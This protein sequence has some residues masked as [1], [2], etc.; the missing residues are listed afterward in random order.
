MR[1]TPTALPDSLRALDA[2]SLR[3]TRRVVSARRGARVE[4]DGRALVDF[5]SNDYLG[6]ASEPSLG[7]ALAE[8]ARTCGAGAAASHLVSGHQRAHAELE[9]ALAAYTRRER[10]LLFST[11]YMANLG[12]V[13][14][15]AGRGD[16]IVE[17]RLNHASLLDASRLAGARVR[18]FAHADAAACEAALDEGG[19]ASSPAA[20]RL[21][22]TDGVFSMDGDVAPV[23]PLAALATRRDAWLVVDDAH[24]LGVLGP[25]GGGVLEAAGLGAAAVPALVGTFGKAFGTFGAFVAGDAPLIEWLVQRARTYAYTT[26]LPAAIAV[27]TRTA[28]D[29]AARETWRRARVL[30]HV[31][32]FRAAAARS[33]VPLGAS[34]TPIQ[35][36]IVGGAE[37]AVA[38]SDALARRGHWVAAIRPPTV[39]RG[40]ARL[41]VSLS[42]AHEERD[43]D[44]LVAALA[45]V[46]EER[47][48][49]TARGAD[50]R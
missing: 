39:P 47:S 49:S 31:D 33:G 12:V 9:A 25:T 21:I 10:A 27:A 32:R 30:A 2:G 44:A 13:T 17:D 18:R 11:G 1:R 23:V 36:V 45:E 48:R 22:A 4:V 3:R 6:L 34:T 40:T 14:A 8:G 38:V 35:P 16:L 5:C 19:A 43:V 29:L 41:R 42:A 26:A 46:L 50:A 28:L 20:G 15:L 7:A 37:G 24:G